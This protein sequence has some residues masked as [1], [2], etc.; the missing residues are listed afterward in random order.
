MAAIA[1]AS[2]LARTAAAGGNSVDVRAWPRMDVVSVQPSE[3][4]RMRLI[5]HLGP[6][7][8]AVN[9]ETTVERGRQDRR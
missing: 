7:L 1:N 2:R 8:A 3:L 9:G 5:P 4:F 6:A